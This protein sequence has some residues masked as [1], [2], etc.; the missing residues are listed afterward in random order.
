MS[1]ANHSKDFANYSIQ[2]VPQADAESAKR[3]GIFNRLFDAIEKSRQREADQVITAY[4]ARS[5]GR[6]TDSVERE[7]MQ[8]LAASSRGGRRSM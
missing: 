8:H 2:L 6:L 4:L 1:F 5:G 7:M 3:T